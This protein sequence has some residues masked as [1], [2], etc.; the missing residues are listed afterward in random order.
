[1]LLN[2]TYSELHLARSLSFSPL[3]MLSLQTSLILRS[4]SFDRFISPLVFTSIPQTLF[5]DSLHVS[6]FLSS[7]I[8]HLNDTDVSTRSMRE[9]CVI[10]GDSYVLSSISPQ[11]ISGGNLT[12]AKC[13]F[14]H[15]RGGTFVLSLTLCSLVITDST[16]VNCSTFLSITSPVNNS[17]IVSSTFSSG[18][19]AAD[20]EMFLLIRAEFT[21]RS[22]KFESASSVEYRLINLTNCVSV[23]IEDCTFS[24]PSK[25]AFVLNATGS[26]DIKI[27]SCNFNAAHFPIGELSDS[28]VM[29]SDSC[30]VPST[31]EGIPQL[32]SLNENAAVHE[33]SKVQ[34]HN[35][36]PWIDVTGTLSSEQKAYAIA[37]V[38]VFFFCFAVLFIG[39]IIFV[40]CKARKEEPLATNMQQDTSLVDDDQDDLD[41]LSG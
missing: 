12:F 7:A 20:S 24:L 29:V 33:D 8:C 3:F 40:F 35:E 9:G 13:T 2:R 6:R 10:S 41:V 4:S 11:S 16:G 26:P 39:L 1:M 15:A 38:V 27:I 37:T 36:C 19:G 17:R 28:L 34:F 30:F 18:E 5:F 21:F 22:V 25:D 31:E 23:R 14:S 32:F